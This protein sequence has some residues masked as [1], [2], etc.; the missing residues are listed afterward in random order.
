MATEYARSHPSEAVLVIDLSP[1]LNASRVL[2]G[3]QNFNALDV[4]MSQGKTIS[5]YLHQ[6][7]FGW[8]PYPENYLTDVSF[9]NDKFPR[10]SN[11]YVE[12]FTL[13]WLVGF[14]NR[15]QTH[16]TLVSGATSPL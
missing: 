1:Q 13:K 2:L 10:I 4:L 15:R 9:F 8:F 11:F 12:T 3:S 7:N 16:S 6:A 5:F 14:W